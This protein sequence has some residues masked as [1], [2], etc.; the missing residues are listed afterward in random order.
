M[1]SPHRW[2]RLEGIPS[3]GRYTWMV[4]S[5]RY[6]PFLEMDGQTAAVLL[7]HSQAQDG[8]MCV[9]RAEA[10]PRFTDPL[11]ALN[12]GR[13]FLS[14]PDFPQDGWELKTDTDPST[15]RGLRWLD[16]VQAIGATGVER[17]PFTTSASELSADLSHF[18]TLGVL[19][20]HEALPQTHLGLLGRAIA[21]YPNEFPGVA[22]ALVLAIGETHPAQYPRVPGPGGF[23]LDLSD[24]ADDV[25]ESQ[26]SNPQ[27]FADYWTSEKKLPWDDDWDEESAAG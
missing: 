22:M 4:F 23:K 10:Y 13:Q 19:C 27:R 11:S 18:S 20:V 16:R 8:Y 25:A 6:P 5:G 2:Q 15:E 26:R 3:G 14:N 24:M 17:L 21:M 12:R 1:L 9:L 7:W